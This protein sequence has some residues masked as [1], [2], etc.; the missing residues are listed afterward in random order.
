M[1]RFNG[2]LILILL[3]IIGVIWGI[4]EYFLDTYNGGHSESPLFI[5]SLHFVMG[6][7]SGGIMIFVYLKINALVRTEERFETALRKSEEQYRAIFEKCPLGV[8][9]FDQ[10]GVVTHCNEHFVKM[11]R[12][13]REEIIGFNMFTQ[14]RDSNV[15]AAVETA[16]SGKESHYEG[17]FRS[18]MS[19]EIL[20]LKMIFNPITSAGGEFLGGVAI[21][22]DIS[23]KRKFEKELARLD[24]LNMVG[25]IASSIGHEVRNPM[26]TVRGFLQLLGMK[27]MDVNKKVYYDLM[28][29]E[30][31]RA[32]S[33]ITEFLSLARDRRVELREVSLNVIINA[34]FP[35]LNA[36]ALKRDNLIIIKQG[37]I[38]RISVSE[39]EIRQ[40][41]LNLVRNALEA[42]PPG[43]KIFISTNVSDGEVVLA[44]EDRGTGIPS[45]I[46]DKIGT[47]FVSTKENG[48]GLGLSICYS[49]AYKHNAKIDFKTSSAGTT[50]YVRFKVQENQTINKQV[51]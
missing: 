34:L 31:D 16:L 26:T 4:T 10:T 13:P 44:V 8:I 24:R 5:M 33:I 40:L 19:G 45:E 39:K 30:L 27:E 6:A 29:D 9:H 25:Q 37:D 12:L 3:G 7:V 42:S 2:R 22:E 18:S 51:C 49:I 43:E 17:K 21:H 48:T 50:F 41:L 28:I 46:F 1:A 36:D 14:V 11:V 23:E 47:P 38:P 20:N 15:K 35:L 32:N